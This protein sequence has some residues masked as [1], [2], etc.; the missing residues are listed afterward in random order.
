MATIKDVANLA[1]VSQAT[2]SRVLNHDHT[3]SVSADTRNRIVDA[4]KQLNYQTIRVRK[5]HTYS[6]APYRIGIFLCLS[7]E[8]E[9]NDPYF[10]SIRQGV[11]QECKALG[12]E[13]MEIYRKY[14]FNT[15][16]LNPNLD[17]LIIIGKVDTEL[18]QYIRGKMKC[19][20]FID[21]SPDED[22]Y[23]SVVI[24]FQKATNLAL[25]HLLESNINT[26]GF[27]GGRQTE[28]TNNQLS[29]TYEDERYLT[30]KQRMREIKQYDKR[31][32][33]IGE[34]TMTTGYRLMKQAIEQGGLPNAFFIASDP[35]AIGALRALRES[36]LRV[37]EDIKI[38]GFDDIEMAQ[39][40]NPPLSTIHVPTEWMGKIGVKL[41]VERLKGRDLPL[42]VTVPTTLIQRESTKMTT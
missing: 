37:P 14:N 2:V 25:D 26:I 1:N 35:M 29:H 31:H 18:I 13:S 11:E 24:D 9:L 41:L 8:E 10:L 38:I 23:D 33:H 34:F 17:G 39:F 20:T 16:Q 6:Q 7:Q 3:L 22:T 4:A 28:Y 15:T 30:F 19:I 32:V 36:G 12:I 21:C 27:I 5:Q 42:K 40:A